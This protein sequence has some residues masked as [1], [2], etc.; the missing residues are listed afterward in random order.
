MKTFKITVELARCIST[1]HRDAKTPVIIIDKILESYKKNLGTI[2]M[3]D[4][5][6]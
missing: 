4:I 5:E 6:T 2:K 3:I 1:V